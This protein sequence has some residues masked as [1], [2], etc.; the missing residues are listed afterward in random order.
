MLRG[1]TIIAVKRNGRVALAG[2]G[3]VTL[4]QSTIIKH[5][6]KK[7]RRLY[8]GRVLAGFAGSVADALALFDRFEGKLEEAQGNLLRAAVNLAKEWRTDKLLRR[9]EA[10]LV[11]AD[12]EHLLMVSGS[13]EV[14]EPD[15][16]II[17]LGSGGPYALAAAR[18]LLNHTQYDA[19]TIAREALKITA[20]ICVYTNENI[21]VEEL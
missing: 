20:S 18:A 5:G 15:D 9:L 1:T 7:V 10:V 12:R 21:T 4:G 3:Q 16:G 14:L 13:G 6:A 17:A 2:D 8:Q 11:V 19:A